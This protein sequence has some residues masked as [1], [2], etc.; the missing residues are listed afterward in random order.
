M[1]K[2]FFGK[3]PAM[4]LTAA[5]AV[6]CVACAARTGDNGNDS[7]SG[8]NDPA[9]TKGISATTV[10]ND[11]ME[12]L[13]RSFG[14]VSAV[15][16]TSDEPGKASGALALPNPYYDNYGTKAAAL[17]ALYETYQGQYMVQYVMNYANAA[18][19][20]P[21]DLEL[22]KVYSTT[23]MMDGFYAYLRVMQKE[24]GVNF[25][26][27]IPAEYNG[28]TVMY[29]YDFDY[30]YDYEASEP[31]AMRMYLTQYN[32]ISQ[33][34]TQAEFVCVNFADINFATNDVNYISLVSDCDDG[35]EEFYSALNAES[36][37]YDAFVASK[38]TAYMIERVS[39]DPAKTDYFVYNYANGS[40]GSG[41]HQVG[42]DDADFRANYDSVYETVKGYMH[43]REFL[44]TSDAVSMGAD[45]YDNM[46]KYSLMVIDNMATVG[47]NIE[48]KAIKSV[49]TARSVVAQIK[50]QLEQN[51]EFN[52]AVEK[53]SRAKEVISA[54]TEYLAAI[55]QSRWFGILSADGKVYISFNAAAGSYTINY[56]DMGAGVV[57][58]VGEDGTVTVDANR[59][60]ADRR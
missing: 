58:T 25:R 49:E 31:T 6:S 19:D 10:V 57:F 37:N 40:V 34:N 17:A 28:V 50:T 12:K 55:N 26:M 16:A 22:G 13:E 32:K 53:Y 48:I 43:T 39:L 11:S 41:S 2:T 51:P 42:T 4:I 5:L 23:Y 9:D 27:E 36:F 20:Y 46:H 29:Q 60:V 54:A 35:G 38:V 8:N 52:S 21:A 56:P 45:L 18:S 14:S 59:T 3:L 44:V 30:D 1:K 24:T 33:G 15:S 7:S 47:G